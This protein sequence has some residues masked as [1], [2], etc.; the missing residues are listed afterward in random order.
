MKKYLGLLLVFL[1]VALMVVGCGETAIEDDPVEDPPDEDI[2]A[3]D[4]DIATLGLGVVTSIGRS[5]D[6]DEENEIMPMAQID[7]VIAAAVFDADGKIVDV[8]IDTAQTR[9]NYD[10]ELQLLSDP[11]EEIRTKKELGDDYGM[12]RASEIEREWDEQIADLEEW[13]IGKTVEEVKALGLHEDGSPDD[14]DLSTQ[15]TMTITSYVA[16]LEK[17]YNNAVAVEGGAARLGLGHKVAINR[18][19]GYDMVNDTEILPMAQVDVVIAAAVFDDAGA[20]SGVLIDTAQTRVNFDAEGQVTSDRAAEYKTKRELGDDYGM[21]RASA[22]E[23]EW[24]EQVIAFEEWM[25]G[26]TVSEITGMELDDAD[27]PED[28][29]LTTSVTMTVSAYLAALEEAYSRAR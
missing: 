3:V 6:Y 26:K 10:E 15:V 5:A 23:K 19:V 11:A 20:V 4:S 7:T 25:I 21:R 14:P 22:I 17:A 8:Q 18:S 9:V 12:R 29:D 27:A 28:P 13:M 2:P 16:A 24:D 1:M